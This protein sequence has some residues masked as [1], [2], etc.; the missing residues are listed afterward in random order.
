M[1]V[2]SFDHLII[3]T[4]ESKFE[5]SDDEPLTLKK[6]V[7]GKPHYYQIVKDEDRIRELKEC[8]QRLER[9]TLETTVWYIE[10]YHPTN[11]GRRSLGFCRLYEKKSESDRPNMDSSSEPEDGWMYFDKMR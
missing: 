5:L 10:E 6:T 4:E 8:M 1:S 7:S 2:V 9:I 11:K 3:K